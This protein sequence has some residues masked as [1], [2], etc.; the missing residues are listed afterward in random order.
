M[1]GCDTAMTIICCADTTNPKNIAIS[2]AFC[3][4]NR[5]RHNIR[6]TDSFF[7]S[8]SDNSLR[9][10]TNVVNPRLVV[11]FFCL[12]A[13]CFFRKHLR[14]FV[15]TS[16]TS[17]SEQNTNYQTEKPLN[18]LLL[19]YKNLSKHQLI[20]AR[21]KKSAPRANPSI[22]LDYLGWQNQLPSIAKRGHLV[23]DV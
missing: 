2:S 5:N 21:I 12:L 8:S 6:S 7:F 23:K 4:N 22:F 10:Y 13:S 1:G 9:V 17:K 15:T 14:L 3:A 19:K 16:L 11:V 18:L 20:W